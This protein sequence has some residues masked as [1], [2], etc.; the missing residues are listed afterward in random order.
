MARFIAVPLLLAFIALLVFIGWSMSTR[1]KRREEQ[2]GQLTRELMRKDELL[3]EVY[4]IAFEAVDVD[5]SAE[6]I[7]MRINDF[8]KKELRGRE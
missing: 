1:Q 7:I 4:D 5:P 6:L 8:R 2:L 3:E